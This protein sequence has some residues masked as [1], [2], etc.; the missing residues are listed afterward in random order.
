MLS[1]TLFLLM[2]LLL[3]VPL[4]MLMYASKGSKMQDAIANDDRRISTIDSD[5]AKRVKHVGDVQLTLL[6][7]YFEC[8]FQQYVIS[9]IKS[10]SEQPLKLISEVEYL[11]RWRPE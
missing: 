10:G 9:L 2:M 3:L 4:Y 5:S 8:R 7:W 1:L 6:E 11:V